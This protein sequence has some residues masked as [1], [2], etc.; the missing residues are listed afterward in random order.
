MALW[1]GTTTLDTVSDI[2]DFVLHIHVWRSLQL[3]MCP[4]INYLIKYLSCLTGRA[5]I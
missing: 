1:S 2:H 4:G 5:D 3:P